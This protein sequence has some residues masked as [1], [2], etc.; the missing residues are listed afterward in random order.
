MEERQ[1]VISR[2]NVREGGGQKNKQFRAF[3][4]SY[5]DGNYCTSLCECFGYA[6][7]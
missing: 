4:D 2:T 6:S 1:V 7:V 3:K 5:D